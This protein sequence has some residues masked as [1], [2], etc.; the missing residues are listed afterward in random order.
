MLDH[1][2]LG[3]LPRPTSLRLLRNSS[4]LRAASEQSVQLFRSAVAS[5]FRRLVHN[6][7]PQ[8]IAGKNPSVP[9][10]PAVPRPSA[11]VIVVNS[12]NE[13][14]L[15][16]RNPKSTSFANAHVFPGGNYDEKQ[17]SQQ[18]FAFTAIRE[19]FEESGLLL[20]HP[21]TGEMPS[22]SE[23]DTA[24]EAI[25]T[26]RLMFHDF[27]SQHGLRPSVESLLPFTQWITPTN[28][29]RRFHARFYVTFLDEVRAAGFS[30]GDKQERLPTPDGGQEVV[31]ARF[32]RPERA[33]ADFAAKHISLY[34]PQVYLLTTLAE[35][36]RAP[37]NTPAERARVR[38]LALGA[39]GHMVI[40]P[41]PLR[42]HDMKAAGYQVLTYEGD[43]TRGGSPGR[44]HRS[45]VWFGVAGGTVGVALERNFDVFT[46]IEPQAFSESAKL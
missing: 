10:A 46:E 11:S 8:Q 16:H 28:V 15:V 26:Q 38:A 39:F 35:L 13:I 24:R 2:S 9:R 43:E 36:L 33:L 42:G 44:L 20:V 22:D 27:L 5:K 14:L 18:G 12:H 41:K 29:P 30:H 45:K 19:L 32:V 37:Q 21:S 3:R 34:P 4:I 25:N 6:M 17:D 31:A 23:L 7:P 1:I 40:N